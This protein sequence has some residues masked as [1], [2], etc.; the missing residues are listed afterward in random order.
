[1]KHHEDKE[2]ASRYLSDLLSA[3]ERAEHERHLAECDECVREMERYRR[4]GA[5]LR[6]LPKVGAPAG[7]HA[8]VMEKISAE[9][10]AERRVAI[11]QS[12]RFRAVAALLVLAAGVGIIFALHNPPEQITGAGAT[13]SKD[14]VKI[15]AERSAESPATTDALGNDAVY[16]Y[17]GASGAT[18]MDDKAADFFGTAITT[19][20][21]APGKYDVFYV[22]NALDKVDYALRNLTI[23]DLQGLASPDQKKFAEFLLSNGSPDIQHAHLTTTT[24]AVVFMQ[25][26]Q[27]R[28]IANAFE[29]AD[30]LDEVS[31][32]IKG[33]VTVPVDDARDAY[34][35]QYELSNAAPRAALKES[36]NREAPTTAPNM[37][38][39]Q[40]P[41]TERKALGAAES[42]APAPSEAVP[43]TEDSRRVAQLEAAG[44]GKNEKAAA[45]EAAKAKEA[46]GIRAPAA[47]HGPLT[48]SEAAKARDED[49]AD[50]LAKEKKEHD[51][52][53]FASES[54]RRYSRAAG[55]AWHAGKYQ[56]NGQLQRQINGDKE[57]AL[58]FKQ[59]IV[60]YAMSLAGERRALNETE[61]NDV[62]LVFDSLPT[63]E[64]YSVDKS[65]KT[66]LNVRLGEDE[67]L[68]LLKY[69]NDMATVKAAIG[70]LKAEL[71]PAETVPADKDMRNEA[72]EDP[73]AVDVRI[74][75]E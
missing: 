52:V 65:A 47:T 1:M 73:Y 22:R 38:A 34:A 57:V 3:E 50:V 11:L 15:I 70:P 44:G 6:N 18:Y 39:P 37:T 60:F 48:T 53:V 54:D 42:G 46:G 23:K 56:Q 41:D 10:P 43:E 59:A 14:E 17:G 36:L 25:L 2:T 27:K 63:L 5:L 19:V 62:Q 71:A 8:S 40:P 26:A 21:D 16:L 24:D 12:W 75:F 69:L 29:K 67:F 74:I 30:K 20:M 4:M 32:V 33:Y 58:E 64:N 35:L 28:V 9:K 45:A 7:L 55:N 49:T 68:R 13:A 61:Q 31:T 51:K 66:G 72:E